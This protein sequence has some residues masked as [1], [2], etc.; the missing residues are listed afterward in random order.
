MVDDKK[1]QKHQS[2]LQ[3]RRLVC[4]FWATVETCRFNMAEQGPAPSVDLKNTTI[5]SFRCSSLN[6]NL[7]KNIVFHFCTRLKSLTLTSNIRS[8]CFH[9]PVRCCA[10]SM[11]SLRRHA[12]GHPLSCT[13]SGAPTH[14]WSTASQR[15]RDAGSVK[16][17][18]DGEEHGVV[19]SDRS[20]LKSA[21]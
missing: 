20:S 7:V 16:R 11:G 18:R 10:I 9:R 3:S 14:T 17:R 1:A 13:C 8:M 2:P 19:L 12:A 4:P 15:S 6:E 5:L 21:I